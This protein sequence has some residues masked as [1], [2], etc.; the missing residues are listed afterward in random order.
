M[1]KTRILLVDDEA[2]VTRSLALYLQSTGK[3]D[4]RAVN[5]SRNAIAVAREFKPDLTILDLMM[6]EVD[7]TEV[8]ARMREDPALTTIP[9]IFLT[10]LVKKGE[11]AAGGGEIG[12][13]PFL[14]KPVD[15]Q[16]V[17]ASIERQLGR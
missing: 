12:G 1:A 14:A 10:A 4:V 16:A 7:G 3:Y 17:V 2:P 15:P 9:I 5:D 6:P 11:V 8:A 13:H